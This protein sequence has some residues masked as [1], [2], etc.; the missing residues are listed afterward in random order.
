MPYI[1]SKARKV[2][3]EQ[4]DIIINIIKKTFSNNHIDSDIKNYIIGHAVIITSGKIEEYIQDI[5]SDYF[6][7]LNSNNIKTNLLPDELRAFLFSEVNLID[8]YKHFVISND[9]RRLIETLSN[10][11]NSDNFAFMYNGLNIP[12][13]V[14]AKIY[15]GVKYPSPKNFN[16]LFRR[17]GIK[18]IFNEIN[19]SSHADLKSTLKSFNDVR[20]ELAHN[21]ILIGKNDKDIKKLLRDIKKFI[22]HIDRALSR[23]TFTISGATTWPS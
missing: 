13:I 16:R 8:S 23:H 1:K 12:N 9:E 4:I 5:L 14:A 10:R 19:K 21:G 18:N 11:I 7:N 22:S 17:L 6:H 3:E 20:T 15:A 2:F